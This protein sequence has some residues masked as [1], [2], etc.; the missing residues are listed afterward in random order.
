M[1]WIFAALTLA[2]EQFPDFLASVCNAKNFINWQEFVRVNLIVCFQEN[3][4]LV[5]LF[6]T[7][8]LNVVPFLFP[9]YITS[10][11]LLPGLAPNDSCPPVTTVVDPPQNLRRSTHSR[12]L[13][14]LRTS[15]TTLQ[16][17][18]YLSPTHPTPSPK[19]VSLSYHFNGIPLS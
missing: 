6:E 7:T 10:S 2:S 14:Q 8:V 17:H 5:V 19:A 3:E 9:Y 18:L 16:V 11:T 15:P 1:K 4:V 13:H 12:R